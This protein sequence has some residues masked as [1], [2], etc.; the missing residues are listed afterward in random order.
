MWQTIDDL[1]AEMEA[2]RQRGSV[3]F[4]ELQ[5][6]PTNFVDYP[7]YQKRQA[8]RRELEAEIDTVKQIMVYINKAIKRETTER[9]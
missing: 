6:I 3:A 4:V 1:K 5:K 9:S 2:Y 8:K 7:I